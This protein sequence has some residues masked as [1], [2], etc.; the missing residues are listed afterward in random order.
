MKFCTRCG[1][2]LSEETRASDKEIEVEIVLRRGFSR[3]VTVHLCPL[4]AVTFDRLVSRFF[5]G[6]AEV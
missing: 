1:T 3:E 2:Q 4:C 6:A 5:D